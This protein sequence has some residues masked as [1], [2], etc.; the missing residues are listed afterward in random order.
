[1]RTMVRRASDLLSRFVGGSE[2][3]IAAAF[4]EA[5]ERGAFLILDEA[6]GLLA[7]RRSATQAWEVT[8]VNELLTWMEHHPLP[9]ACT[10]NLPER[11]D[12]ACRRR[13]LI[14]ITFAPLDAARA[15]AA[16]ARF[17]LRPAP[18]GLE[19][20][21]PLVPADL[22]LAA[23]KARLFGTE[24]DDEAVL[25]LLREEAAARGATAPIGFRLAR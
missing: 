3:A 19:A 2:R 6:D 17:F 18:P 15:R 12:P 7:D 23:R 5:R 4:A 25:A 8:Q 9:F 1:M 24:E 13:F 20:L 11:L 14:K 16:F 21:P 22:A 10:T